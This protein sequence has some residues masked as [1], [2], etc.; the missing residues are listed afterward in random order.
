[1]TCGNEGHDAFAPAGIA[2]VFAITSGFSPPYNTIIWP[3]RWISWYAQIYTAW[4]LI[5]ATLSHMCYRCVLS[6]GHARP[7]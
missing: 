3:L 4:L 5:V 6:D 1:V 2:L 7:I